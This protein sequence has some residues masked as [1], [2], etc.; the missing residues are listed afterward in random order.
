[1]TSLI[2]RHYANEHYATIFNPEYGF[3]ARLEE[4]GYPK[5][6]WANHGPELIDIS[7]TGWCDRHCSTC[8]RSSTPERRHMLFSDYETV[9]R[10]AVKLNVEAVE[11]VLKA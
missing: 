11:K 8:Y 3:F 10:Q 9:I 2:S 1:M 4:P 6:F 5:P 7:V